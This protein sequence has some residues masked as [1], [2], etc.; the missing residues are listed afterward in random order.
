MI[1]AQT[2]AKTKGVDRCGKFIAPDEYC[3]LYAGHYKFCGLMPEHK[4]W[5]DRDGYCKECGRDGGIEVRG[6]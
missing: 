3:E 4:H 5:F 6:P 1:E 2:M